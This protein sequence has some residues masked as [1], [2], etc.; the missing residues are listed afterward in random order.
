MF[1]KKL[2]QYQQSGNRISAMQMKDSLSKAD[3]ARKTMLESFI[4][5]HPNSD[6]SL[7]AMNIYSFVNQE[8]PE[9]VNSL[10][11]T[12]G[13]ELQETDEMIEIKRTAEENKNFIKGA[14]APDFTQTDTSGAAIT[15]SSLQGKFVLI[16]FWASWCKPCRAQNPSMLRLYQKY[17]NKGFTILGVSL[18]A[19]KEAWLKAIHDDK[20]EWQHVSDLKFWSNDVAKQYKITSVPQ[21]FLLDPKGVIIG[22]N[23]SGDDLD[24]LLEKELGK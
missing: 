20:L 10:L 5:Q 18:D 17:K 1:D 22:K 7:Y 14:K 23:L 3:V 6:L 8:N 19:K 24:Q 16:D 11:S 9:E 15:L 4:R 2:H 13:K 21:N 12:L